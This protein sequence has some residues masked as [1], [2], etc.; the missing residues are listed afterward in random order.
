MTPNKRKLPQLPLL[1][2]LEIPEPADDD[3]IILPSAEPV[4]KRTC[5]RPEADLDL[6]SV[7]AEWRLYQTEQEI[8]Q[9]DLEAAQ[10]ARASAQKSL[11]HE[12]DQDQDDQP[13]PAPRSIAFRP[14]A[15]ACADLDSVPLFD[16]TKAGLSNNHMVLD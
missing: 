15:P 9:E 14:I 3:W 13:L 11:G 16:L 5:R 7:F 10:A 2:A 6:V 12:E 4:A 8:Q 1:T